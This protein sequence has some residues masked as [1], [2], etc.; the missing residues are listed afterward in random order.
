MNK[1]SK[2]PKNMHFNFCELDEKNTALVI[3]AENDQ[4]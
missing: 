4:Q 3:N 2:D 1:P